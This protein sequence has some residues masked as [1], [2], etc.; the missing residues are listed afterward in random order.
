M[1]NTLTVIIR[2]SPTITT[3]PHLEN[4][5]A[6]DGYW[7][8]TGKNNSWEYGT[9]NA[10]KITRAASGSKAWKTN[11]TGNYK[12]QQLSYLYSPCY[13]ISG[14]TN[15]TL[16]LSIAL[17]LEDCGNNDGDLCDGAFMEYSADGVTWTRL[18]AYN[19]GKNLRKLRLTSSA[20]LTI[21]VFPPSC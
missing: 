12:D 1:L 11:L 18:G 8:T 4:F 15:P 21:P 2:N 9:P 16:S 20:T 3:F 17:D 13:N 5:E 10:A 7:Y 19:Q 14:L 6:G